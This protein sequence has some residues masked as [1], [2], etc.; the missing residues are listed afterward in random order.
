MRE[1]AVFTFFGSQLSARQRV[2]ATGAAAPRERGRAAAGSAGQRPGQGRGAAEQQRREGPEGAQRQSHGSGPEC[3]TCRA[4]RQEGSTPGIGPG[5]RENAAG[6]AR[7]LPAL[8]ARPLHICPDVPVTQTHGCRAGASP[9][10][11]LC[12]HQR[13]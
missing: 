6:R 11:R 4:E 2:L 7:R 13:G 12:A 5:R 3:H 8:S 1:A 10:Y 9:R